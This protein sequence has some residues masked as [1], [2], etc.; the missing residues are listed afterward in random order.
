MSDDLGWKT[1]CHVKRVID[2]DTVE[3]EIVRRFN[4][5]LTHPDGR[6]H[7]D[8]GTEKDRDAARLLQHLTMV[9]N[10]VHLF[11][12]ANSP[13]KLMD[14]NSFNRVLGELFTTNGKRVTDVLLERGSAHLE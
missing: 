7:V 1:H 11:I 10:G 5:R 9:A 13:E 4:V 6:F 8:D 12:P 14:I 3:V 2:G